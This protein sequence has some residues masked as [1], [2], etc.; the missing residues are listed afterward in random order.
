MKKYWR[1]LEE[2]RRLNDI[3]YKKCS[4]NLIRAVNS[5]K[6]LIDLLKL[7]KMVKIREIRETIAET[8]E[9]IEDIEKTLEIILQKTEE[10][11]ELEKLF[12]EIKFP[13]A[14]DE[15]QFIEFVAAKHPEKLEVI[16]D[17]ISDSAKSH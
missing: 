11:E 15:Q 17:Y 4:D 1:K 14:A 9:I 3:N 12:Q 6:K 7:A 5:R 2:F 8:D 13:N 10:I 16:Q